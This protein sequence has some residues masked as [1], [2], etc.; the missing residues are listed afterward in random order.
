M[1][2]EL[3]YRALFEASHDA[4]CAAGTEGHVVD[5]NP[6]MLRLLDMTREN[7]LELKIEQ[8]FAD[9]LDWLGLRDRLDQKESVRNMEVRLR[10]S[11]GSDVPVLF[12]MIS[13]QQGEDSGASS[14][15]IIHDI[16]SRRNAEERLDH[17]A[18]HD[19]LT[20]LPNRRSFLDRV[21]RLFDR[22]RFKPD[23]RFGVLFVDL[24]RFK[25]VNDSMG[26]RWGDDLLVLV[27][28]RLVQAVR[29]EDI[30]ARL[31]GDEFAILA[32]DL[33]GAEEAATVATRVQE[34]LGEPF[35]I[36]GH[37]VHAS[38]SV[39]IVVSDDTY[40][41][42]E[43][44]I[45][46]ADTAMYAAKEEGGRSWAL[47]DASM[48]DRV[49]KRVATEV[50]L[51]DALEKNEF[52]IHYQPVYSAATRH[53]TGFEALLR[54]QHPDRGLV[55][56]ADF[57]PVAEESGLIAPIGDW[58]LREVCTVAARWRQETT[59]VPPIAVNVSP[60]QLYLPGLA[61]RLEELLG[62]YSLPGTSLRL[63]V[64]ESTFLKGSPT[65]NDTLREIQALGVDLCLDNFGT[66]YSTLGHLRNLPFRTIK[67]DR[68]FI[69]RL[70]SDGL[71]MVEAVLALAKTMGLETVAE[72]VETEDEMADLQR[73]GCD[74]VQGYLFSAPVE[75]GQ[76]LT[77]LKLGRAPK[78][79]IAP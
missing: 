13:L 15:S 64:T 5:A 6:A 24:D 71:G 63:D 12:T 20:Q 30:V 55:L 73:V 72:G 26:H 54:W 37:S 56:P 2:P 21:S 62:E 66:R 31:G 60:Q 29:P 34:A 16:T 67:I 1:P 42:A 18:L 76:A 33:P 59:H 61:S 51:R 70:D 3:A 77:L 46:D 65:L 50:A 4:V 52:V 44:M 74:T 17:A 25:L 48:R 79:E 41:S 58:V 27:G 75:V 69:G 14:L 36:Q 43:D 45:R 19:S 22:R 78:T 57:L 9:R 32:I 47:F 40:Q 39:G 28:E 7:L 53:L 38:A 11:D 8:L 35:D 49:V 10:R 68:A 23:Y